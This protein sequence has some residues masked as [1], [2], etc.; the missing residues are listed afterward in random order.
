M[1]VVIIED[2]MAA[3]TNIKNLLEAIEPNIEIV[4]HLDTVADSIH[5]FQT[6]MLPDIIFMDIQL[7]DGC[8]FHLFDSVTIDVPIIFTTAY[9]QYAIKAF[10]VNS[11][12]YLLK[13]IT[14]EA[15]QKAFIKYKKYNSN[16]SEV[17]DPFTWSTEHVRRLLVPYRD[18]IL[19]IKTDEIAYFYNTNGKTNLVTKEGQSY[20]LHKSLD[21]LMIRLDNRQFYR[22]NR[23]CIVS[24][25]EIDSF[26]VWGDNRLQLLIKQSTEEPILVA[27]NKAAEFKEW[28]MAY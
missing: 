19:P 16:L 2:E 10:E 11:I 9:D 8:I 14:Y 20:W 26:I 27:K 28:L 23:Q 18:K 15:I 21:T 24:R 7:A 4:A 3:F 1:K 6:N 22:A 12:D 17:S 5:W 25:E 13:P